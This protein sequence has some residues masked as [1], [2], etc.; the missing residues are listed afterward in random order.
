M[1]RFNSLFSGCVSTA[2]T[3][4]IACLANSRGSAGVESNSPTDLLSKGIVVDPKS[5]SRT[6]SSSQLANSKRP[7]MMFSADRLVTNS[8]TSTLMSGAG[9]ANRLASVISMRGNAIPNCCT[10]VPNPMST[11]PLGVIVI[12]SLNGAAPSA[13]ATSTPAS[14]FNGLLAD[15]PVA[16]MVPEIGPSENPKSAL[17]VS[18]LVPR[19]N[20]FNVKEPLTPESESPMA[21]VTSRSA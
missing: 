1:N 13:I 16:V 9:D 2:L 18:N 19:R 7:L 20:W 5:P 3:L 10:V 17:G 8:L 11:D 14:T 15:A 6:A 21:N 12:R 4:K